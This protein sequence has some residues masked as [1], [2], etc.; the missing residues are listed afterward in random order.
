MTDFALMRDY[1]MRFIGIPYIYGG[2]NPLQGLDC[3]GLVLELLTA[4]GLWHAGDASAQGVYNALRA[5]GLRGLAEGAAPQL[6]AV[7]FFG[8]N[9]TAISHIAF[10]ISDTHML[11]AGGGDHTTKTPADAAARGA[12]V[13]I[14][15]QDRR[16]DRVDVVMLS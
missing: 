2:N 16:A 1:G 9:R 7:I 10:C 13:R 4:A 14:R 8:M 12:F 11:E 6:G 3:S 15:R 5:R